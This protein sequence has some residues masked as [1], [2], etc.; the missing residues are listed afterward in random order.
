MVTAAVVASFV[1]C[2]E[3]WRQREG[4]GLRPENRAAIEAGT[5]HHA[6]KAVVERVAG[7]SLA[8][9]R[10]LVALAMLGLLVLWV[11]SR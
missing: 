2:R 11:L 5:Q 4:L 3:Q 1:Y 9:G 6:R 8:I 10:L 7:G